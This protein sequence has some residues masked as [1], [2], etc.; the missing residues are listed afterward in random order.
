MDLK[1][2]IAWVKANQDKVSVG[3]GAHIRQV[4]E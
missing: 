1:E 4:L 2:L 3:T